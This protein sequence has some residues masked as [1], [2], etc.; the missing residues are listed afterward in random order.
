M[1]TSQHT[2]AVL[3]MILIGHDEGSVICDMFTGAGTRVGSTGTKMVES[4]LHVQRKEAR[5]GG[6][7]RSNGD[8]DPATLLATWVTSDRQPSRAPIRPW[9]G[10][11]GGLNEPLCVKCSP[12]ARRRCGMDVPALAALT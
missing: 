11:L 10:L 8:W 2:Q 5:P 1:T 7:A 9:S 12:S 3:P 4:A 6:H